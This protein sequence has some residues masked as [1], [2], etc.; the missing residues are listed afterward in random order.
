MKICLIIPNLRRGGAEKVALD[1]SN[2][3]NKVEEV[4]MVLISLFDNDTSN[5]YLNELDPGVEYH[6]L[7]KGKG[8]D[9][10]IL[11]KLFRLLGKIKADTLHAH[12]ND[13]SISKQ[14]KVLGVLPH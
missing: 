13:I 2:G 14:F 12:I 8:F 1:L 6:S 7:G 9:P 5:T 4:E 10:G 11:L 3:F